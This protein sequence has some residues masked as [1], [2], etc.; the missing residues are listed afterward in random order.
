MT[1]TMLATY[2]DFTRTIVAG[3]SAVYWEFAVG[4]DVWCIDVVNTGAGVNTYSVIGLIDDDG[5]AHSGLVDAAL[6]SSAIA[7]GAHF[8]F[9][10]SG[11]TA[12][13]TRYVFVAP[14]G[15]AVVATTLEFHVTR[16]PVF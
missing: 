6:V 2:W 10:A 12:P 11:A 5:G 4:N 3:V 16:R 7:A 9:N 13:N 1:V 14:G 15:G 8:K